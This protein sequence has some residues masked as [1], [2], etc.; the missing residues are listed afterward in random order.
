MASVGTI[1][2]DPGIV[3]LA[4]PATS[5][6]IV[7]GQGV[8]WELGLLY[9]RPATTGDARVYGIAVSDSDTD[10][11][12]VAVAVKGGYTVPAQPAT[13]QTFVTGA[14]MYTDIAGGTGKVTSVATGNLLLGWA[15]TGQ[16]DAQ[17]NYEMA[18]FAAP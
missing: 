5:P 11:L 14:L 15:T 2:R 9:A 16:P 3:S 12:N 13:G 8:V 4:V 1:I 18:F 10:L 7:R 6:A 17:G